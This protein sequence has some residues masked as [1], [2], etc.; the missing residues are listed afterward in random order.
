[1]AFSG[2]I[3]VDAFSVFFHLLIAAVVVV[4]LLGSLDYF[5]GWATEKNS[6]HA[7]EYFALVLFGAT[8]MMLMTC[9]GGAADGVYRAGD[10][11]NFDVYPGGLP[12]G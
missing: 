9:V 11:V 8:G 2:N 7:G 1:M 6:G 5:D 4:T 12:Q 10:L 3:Q